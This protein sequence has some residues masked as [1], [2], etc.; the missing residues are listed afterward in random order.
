MRRI[1]A[2]STVLAG[3][4]LGA[5]TPVV[6]VPAEAPTPEAATQQAAD[7]KAPGGALIIKKPE[8]VPP[9]APAP[10]Q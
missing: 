2:I 3:A 4:V 1:T 8:E 6:V 10:K 5:C 9:V 7:P